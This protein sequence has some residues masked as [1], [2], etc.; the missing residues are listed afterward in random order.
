M[1]RCYRHTPKAACVLAVVEVTYPAGKLLV[2]GFRCPLCG[3]EYF[4]GDQVAES[5][6]R[7]EELGLFGPRRVSRRKLRQVGSSLS[8]TL[9]RGILRELL[10]DAK[11]GDEVEVGLEGDKIVI[12]PVDD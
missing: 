5:Q 2:E 12:R 4:T 9:D 6:R 10:P 7:A 8:V 3:E 11:A 1:P